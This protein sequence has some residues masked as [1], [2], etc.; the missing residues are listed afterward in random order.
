MSTKMTAGGK[1]AL[2]RILPGCGGT[3]GVMWLLAQRIR[4]SGSMDLREILGSE[5]DH[6]DNAALIE[7]LSTCEKVNGLIDIDGVITHFASYKHLHK[8]DEVQTTVAAELPREVQAVAHTLLPLTLLAGQYA[9]ENGD[10][11]MPISGLTQFGPT[12]G[13]PYAHLASLIWLEDGGLSA[14]ILERQA[15]GGVLD[16]AA[17]VEELDYHQ[18]PKLMA[19]TAKAN[20]ML[21]K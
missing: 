12:K 21:N 7:L 11:S 5:L 16:R 17:Q 13:T 9:Y 8:F 14:K 2:V 18:A 15:V 10:V 19:A 1:D 4:D 6:P 3:L 20:E